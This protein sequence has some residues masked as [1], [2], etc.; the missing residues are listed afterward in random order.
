MAA[1]LRVLALLV[2]T[3]TTSAYAAAEK[4]FVNSEIAQD[5]IR[6]E[7]YLKK[8]LKPDGKTAAFWRKQGDQAT[9]AKDARKAMGAYAQAAF[10]EPKDGST[11]LSLARAIIDTPPADDNERYN[12]PTNA[13]A[14]AYIAYQRAGS[15]DVKAS[16]LATLAETLKSRS[17]WRPA[18]EAYKSSLT[19]AENASVRTAFE[20]L[21]AEQGFRILDYTVDADAASPRLC[22]QFSEQLGKGQSEL[23]KFISVDGKDPANVVVQDSELC[24]EGLEHG[25]RYQ[26][27]VRAGLPSTV[28]EDLLKTADLTIYVRDR[29]PQARFTGKNYVLPNKGQQGIP[30]VT[31]NTDKVA[32]EVLRIGDR[33]LSR[34]VIDGE[35]QAQYSGYQIDDLRQKSGAPVW[36]GE[37]PVKLSLNQEVT[38]AFPVSEAIP[39]LT[40]G[41]YVM[42]AKPA[43]ANSTDDYNQQATQWFVV[44]DL[45]LTA[46]S[47]QDGVHAFVRSLASAE[48]ITGTTVRLVAKNNDVLSTS[49]T[50]AKGYVHFEAGLTRGEG[51]LA[52]A[53]L[54]AE[55]KE[56][57]YAFLD[58]TTGAFDLTD[59]GVSG[60]ETP[61]PLDAYVFPERGVYRPGEDVHLTALLRDRNA[62]AAAG[63]PLTMIVT[64]PDGVEQQRLVLTD[65]GQGGRVTTLTLGASSMTG[66]WRVSVHA[67]PEAA[68]VGTTSFLVE[69][70]VPER[71]DLTLTPAIV[72]FQPGT[73]G[74][75]KADGRYLYGPPAAD[76]GIEGEVSVA[77]S[78]G[79]LEGFAGYQFGLAD[80]SVSPVRADLSGLPNTDSAGH[81]N[82]PVVLPALPHTS[83][84]LEAKVLLRLRE[85]SGR[86]I[87]R[88]VTLPVMPDHPVIGIKPLFD[89]NLGRGG[90]AAFNV[91]LVGPDGKPQ[92]AKGLK[93]QLLRID[94]SYQWYG[95]NG[96]WNY[97]PVIYTNKMAEGTLDTDGTSPATVKAPVEWG[98]YRL[99]V[100]SAEASGPASSAAFSAGWYGTETAD[101]PEVLDIGLDRADYKPG[102]TARLD[103]KTELGGR[104]M[105]A[106]MRDELIS[107]QEV[108]VPAGGTGIDLKVEQSWAP[109]TYVTAVLY[110]PMDIGAKRMPSRSIG[111]KWLAVDPASRTLGITLATPEKV[112]SAST[113]KVPVKL[114][115]LAPGE[116]AHLVVAAV[117]VGI[118][119]LTRFATPAPDAWFY[120][121][122]TLGLEIRDLYGRLIDGMRAEKGSIRSGG[123]GGLSQTLGSPPT[124]EPVALFSGLVTVGNDGNAEVTFNLPE[125][126]GS[127]RVMAVAWSKTKTGH[128]DREVIVRDPVAM[129][130]SGP[131]FIT[132]GDETRLVFDLHNVEGQTGTYRLAVDGAD[133]TG[134]KAGSLASDV[135]L[136]AGQRKLE[137]LV[138]KAGRIGHT[139]FTVHLTGPGGIDV[140]REFALEVKA[141][142]GDIKRTTGQTLAAK[143]G[144]IA[145]SSDVIADLVPET[146]KVTV[147]V[148]ASAGIDV[149]GLLVQLD[150]YPYG[151]A[152]QTTSRALPLLYYDTVAAAAG[153]T[154]DTGAKERIQKSIDRLF[155]MQDASGAFGLWGPGSSDLWLSAYVADFLTRAKEQ[156]Y[157]V[158]T[159]AFSLA[160]DRLQNSVATAADFESGGEEIAYALYVLARNGRA[161]IGDLRYYVDT[162]LDHFSTAMGKAQIGAALALYGDKDRAERA[163]G[164][165]VAQIDNDAADVDRFDY[166]SILRDS[167]ATLT[168]VSET[169]MRKDTAAHLAEVVTQTRLDRKY[170]STQENAWMLLAARA[171][172]ESDKTLPLSV[173]G[174]PYQGSYMKAFKAEDLKG[175]PVTIGNES[176]VNVQAVITV[177]GESLQPEPASSN[178]FTVS[179]KV[180][181][182]DGKEVDLAKAVLK[183]N[184]RLVIVLK[185]ASTDN[186]GGRAL[187]V[188]RLPAGLEVEN[189]HLVEGGSIASLSWLGS[190]TSPEHQEFRDDRFVAAF[191][192]DASSENQSSESSEGSENS[193]GS[194]T[195]G[196]DAAGTAAPTG[197]SATVAYVVR[198]VTPGKYVHPGASVE[199]MYRPERYARSGSGSVE[200][201]AVQ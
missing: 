118:L 126:N 59:R 109:G 47:G 18:L 24:V 158:P 39:Q 28:D 103:I 40:P 137:A 182:L 140:S 162:R 83:R 117:D 60:R 156:A 155:E 179:R 159:R 48:P 157:T 46:F 148:G 17:Y 11:W 121:Q 45:G 54:V 95:R 167:A 134:T 119:N 86:T 30:V 65:Q 200:V 122:R 112:P 97:E 96:T 55:A 49:T 53:I 197:P 138:F 56:G 76:L 41:V 106:V 77:Q 89:S 6:Y 142:G 67:D 105:I 68:A 165:A 1:V 135:P 195:T 193:A 31:I 192:L 116:E 125:F 21:R 15:K 84:L 37:L 132:L 87:E 184:D 180:F 130:I 154:S 90:E 32:I 42:I 152:E 27:A 178:G 123:D 131:R 100:A 25:Q 4:P 108:E 33:G 79:G 3:F 166:G 7:G 58:M 19:F 43:N 72:A 172:I 9:R 187:L 75:I 12:F 102:D 144:K 136:D 127:L 170:T 111:V 26:V 104:A 115:G 196:G 150:R 128:A 34:A 50:D 13:S 153:L 61:G 85:P 20:T 91:V 169:G 98:S 164:A 190:T 175:G 120:S 22:I 81:A 82:V 64:R 52:P 78:S 69:D 199:D 141:P 185:V 160:L 149:P 23:A 191:N 38:T 173:N 198:A 63:I 29:S 62:D 143:G 171:S 139:G 99:D 80:E 124:Q 8:A 194:D 92:A 129:L 14:A 66:T 174:V 201:K 189:P 186:L 35:F 2:L 176:D 151:C 36:K 114:A 183:Q 161:P 94:R 147:A 44:S 73:E 93:W 168:L 5:A 110:R 70:Y 113:L 133:E 51:G 74:I 16:A 57:D 88:S 163:F 10:T 71:M 177:T 188:D 146:A 145:V 181:T 107:M 101:S